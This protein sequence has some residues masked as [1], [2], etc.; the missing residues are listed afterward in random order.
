M[1]IWG[2]DN[3]EVVRFLYDLRN[4][5]SL[6]RE[7]ENYL[8]K[9]SEVKIICNGGHGDLKFSCDGDQRKDQTVFRVANNKL[10]IEDNDGGA[11]HIDNR[12]ML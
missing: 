8:D 7:Y 9:G 5:I 3:I 11:V 12:A 2:L 10:V 4:N 6:R 1:Q